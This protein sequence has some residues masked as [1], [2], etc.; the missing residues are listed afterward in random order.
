M[1]ILTYLQLLIERIFIG[2][3]ELCR[4]VDPFTIGFLI[5]SILS[6]GYTGYS[7]NQAAKQQAKQA[8]DNAEYN[9]NVAKIE[10][11]QE[12]MNREAQRKEEKIAAHKR[13]ASMEA[14]I[15]KSGLTPIGT[16]GEML[17][18]EASNFQLAT[19]RGDQASSSRQSA[20][21][22]QGALSLWE[23]ENLSSAYE[24]QADTAVISAGLE[25]GQAYT[26]YN[27][28]AN[29]KKDYESSL[30]TNSKTK[31]PIYVSKVYGRLK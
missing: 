31:K 23:G 5:F 12:A 7:Q 15:A 29:L 19:M 20:M 8:E 16:P 2:D 22:Q 1:E 27:Y 9:A 6:A 21:A 24:T 4:A 11:E 30:V 18:E 25:M 26:A 14:N 28:N 17:A 10:A 3:P 13:F